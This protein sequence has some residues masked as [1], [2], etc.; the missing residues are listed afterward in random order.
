MRKLTD[1]KIKAIQRDRSRGASYEALA[2]RHG[3]SAGSIRNALSAKPEGTHTPKAKRGAKPPVAPSSEPDEAPAPVTREGL[4]N[5]LQGLAGELQ[6]DLQGETEAPARAAVARVLATVTSTL[7]RLVPDEAA[8]QG[9]FVTN[10]SMAAAAKL[11]RD[12]LHALLDT[13]PEVQCEACRKLRGE[14]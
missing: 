12:R 7:A 8:P 11:L 6:R 4:A 13:S 10:E 1:D 3:V 5:M 14:S 9:T 2:K